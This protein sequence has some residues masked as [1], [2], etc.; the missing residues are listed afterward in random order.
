MNMYIFE[1]DQNALDWISC[2]I[3]D[4]LYFG[5][6][7]NQIMIEQMINQHHFNVIVNLTCDNEEKEYIVNEKESKYVLFPVKDNDFPD[8]IHSY[9]NFIFFLKGEIEKG[10]KI[11]IHC[12]GGHGRSS[13][14]CVSTYMV[15]YM[16]DLK[17]SIEFISKAHNERV[18]LREK[19]KKCKF[20]FGNWKLKRK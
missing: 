3:P 2:V 18:V 10:N 19:W 8:C 15:I 11:Y 5:P 7:P 9:C 4:Q 6:Y 16:T 14:V 17:S 12:R 20:P 13:M 1:K